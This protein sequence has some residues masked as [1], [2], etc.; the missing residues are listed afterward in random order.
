[1]L[2][3]VRRLMTSNWLVVTATFSLAASTA[4]LVNELAIGLIHA[5]IL[6]RNI[7]FYFIQRIF[8]LALWYAVLALH[9]LDFQCR[10]SKR[11]HNF[12]WVILFADI[13]LIWILKT[14]GSM[15]GK[16]KWSSHGV[17]TTSGRILIHFDL[18]GSTF[19]FRTCRAPFVFAWCVGKDPTDLL[20]SLVSACN[21]I[22]GQVVCPGTLVCWR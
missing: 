8:V 15:R 12:S 19:E 9:N 3:R 11:P 10:C 1:M 5:S 17:W 6:S 13:D 4:E 20:K 22:L 7:S 16:L 2:T 21:L 14:K 18:T